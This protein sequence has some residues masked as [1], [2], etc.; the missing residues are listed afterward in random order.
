MSLERRVAAGCF[1]FRLH[2]TGESTHIFLL[3]LFLGRKIDCDFEGR[4]IDSTNLKVLVGRCRDRPSSALL[5]ICPKEKPLNQRRKRKNA[6][7][8]KREKDKKKNKEN[9][10][11][12][13]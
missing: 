9:S 12:K 8:K 4:K 7:N 3:L 6:S 11:M 1:F 2:N 10:K 5:L 13:K